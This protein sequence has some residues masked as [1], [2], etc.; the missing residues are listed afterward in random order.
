M[1]PAPTTST[2]EDG[3]TTVANVFTP[4][5]RINPG[6]IMKNNI[7]YMY[8]GMIEVDDRQYT[9]NDFYS[10]GKKQIH[11]FLVIDNFSI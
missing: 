7:L 6:L 1:G 10:L 2:T 8:G 9:L 11:I 3:T 5:P 4:S